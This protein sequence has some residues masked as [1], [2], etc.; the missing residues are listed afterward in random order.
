MATS[1]TVF[2]IKR[3]RTSKS[4]YFIP[5]LYDNPLRKRFVSIFAL[6]FSQTKEIL[7]LSGGVTLIDSAKSSLFTQSTQASKTERQT[8]KHTDGQ[9]DRQTDRQADIRTDRQ[10]DRQTYGRTDRQ[11]DRQADRRTDRQ[12]DRHTDGR[13]DGR[14]DRQTGRQTDRRTDRQAE[15]QTNTQIKRQTDRRT[16]RQ[17]DRRQK[18][19]LN[20][21]NALQ[22]HCVTLAK[23]RCDLLSESSGKQPVEYPSVDN[24][25]R[26]YL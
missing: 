23:K 12:T 14:T 13:T 4:R 11:T 19:D 10:T 2:K 7:D 25:R 5:L 18:C 17:T 20:N 8:D 22:M 3:G 9:T 26:I 6:F 24:T 1:G 15:R 21:G 16:D